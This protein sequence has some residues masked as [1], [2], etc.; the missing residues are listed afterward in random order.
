M[1]ER[2]GER[3]AVAVP[4]ASHAIAASQPD[5]TAQLILQAADL[6]AAA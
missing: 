3:R 1:A 5:V 6:H 2:A 4:G